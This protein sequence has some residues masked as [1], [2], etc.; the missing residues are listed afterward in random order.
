MTGTT[1][2]EI[3]GRRMRAHFRRLVASPQFAAVIDCVFDL[4]PKRTSPAFAELCLV[5]GRL[6][7]ARAEG[8]KTFRHFVGRRDQLAA[9]LLAYVTHLK[10]GEP[11]R[12][13]VLSRIDAI[14]TRAVR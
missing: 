9:N 7:F 1:Q 8:E 13:Y 3:A 10:L 5:N 12:E 6:I 4:H 11:D 2:A 14:P